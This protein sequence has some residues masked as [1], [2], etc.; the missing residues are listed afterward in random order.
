MKISASFLQD[1]TKIKELT[2]SNID[3]LHCDIMDGK[4]VLNKTNFFE[5]LE[6]N[7]KEIKKPLDVHLMVKDIYSYINLFSSLEPEFITFHLEI[8]DTYN[9]IHYLK[10]KNIKVGISIKPNTNIEEIIPFLISI[11]LV[12]IMSVEPGLGGQEFLLNSINKVNFLHDYKKRNNLDYLIEV[13]GGINNSNIKLL[14]NADLVV[15]GSYLTNENNIKEKVE[16][17]KSIM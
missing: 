8:G 16:Y 2:N 15:I 9:I 13:D 17:L 12:L 11:D 14:K 5:I 6:N 7:K 3:Y 1:V 10:E 4:F